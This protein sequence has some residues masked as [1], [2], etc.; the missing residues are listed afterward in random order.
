ML[1]SST[2]FFHLYYCPLVLDPRLKLT[3]YK[4]NNWEEQYITETRKVVSDLYE[5]QYAPTTDEDVNDDNEHSEDDLFC[6]IYKK[7][8]LSNSENELDL[9]L[10]TPTVPSEV[11]LLQWW[12]VYSIKIKSYLPNLQ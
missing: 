6:H 2:Y 7:R 9:Y 3:Y 11:N 5:K 12:K 10:G 4:N 8:R 1:I